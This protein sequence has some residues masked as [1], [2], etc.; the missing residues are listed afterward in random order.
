MAGGSSLELAKKFRRNVKNLKSSEKVTIKSLNKDKPTKQEVDDAQVFTIEIA[1]TY[2]YNLKLSN[3]IQETMATWA[4]RWLQDDK[5]QKVV[6]DSKLLNKARSNI[7]VKK[8]EKLI[9][10]SKI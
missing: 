4:D 10:F 8:I 9:N 3:A 1:N 5:V 2:L 6:K 7:K